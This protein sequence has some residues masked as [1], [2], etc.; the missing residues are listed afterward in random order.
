M[1]A[2]PLKYLLHI[3]LALPT[4]ILPMP[5]VK[6]YLL[7]AVIMSGIMTKLFKEINLFFKNLFKIVK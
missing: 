1:L 6:Q 4:D 3:S 7:S 2:W 5:S